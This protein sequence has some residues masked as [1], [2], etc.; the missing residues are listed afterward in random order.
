MHSFNLT[1]W[2]FIILFLFG[3]ISGLHFTREFLIPVAFATVLAMLLLPLSRWFEKKGLGRGMAALIS[4]L[5]ILF[6]LTGIIWLLSWQISTFSEDFG[7]IK[8]KISGFAIQAREY[9]SNTL[10]IS[11]DQ[12][13]KIMKQQQSGGGGAGKM[14][15]SILSAVMG[16][17]VDFILILVY[18]FLLLFFRSHLKKFVM[19]QMKGDEKPEARIMIEGSS[20]V[21]QQYLSGLGLMIVCLWIM[22]GIGFSIVGVKHAIFFA[23]LCGLL[24]IIPFVGNLTG[25]SLTILMAASQGGSSGMIIGIIITYLVVQF[26]Q[27]YILEPLVV[28]AEVNINPLFTILVL[29][30]GELVWGIAGLVLAIPLLGMVKIICDH[31]DPL[32]PY[33]FLIGGEKKAK[34]K[35]GIIEKIKGKF[36]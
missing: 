5:L 27:T 13:K 19:M 29:V 34:S 24:E 6:L 11:Q 10:G 16:I 3:L 31:V 4:I 1:R 25:T 18:I 2:V 30:A 15:T 28:G 8:Q 36:K 17:L 14:V 22:Y 32:K 23:I 26:L 12:Q 20:K 7:N 33:G 9:V 35:S 21:V